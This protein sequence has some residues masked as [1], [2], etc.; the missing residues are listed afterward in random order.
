MKP[1]HRTRTEFDNQRYM[2]IARGL[3]TANKLKQYLFVVLVS[4]AFWLWLAKDFALSILFGKLESGSLAITCITGLG[5]LF[6][7]GRLTA[8]E[9]N[10][11][12]SIR[13]T[14][15][16]GW[17]LTFYCYCVFSGILSGDTM[18]T[19]F[20]LVTLLISIIMAYA[21]A[22]K[23]VQAVMINM[24]L[25]GAIGLLF[26]FAGFFKFHS[27]LKALSSISIG[28]R[29]HGMAHLNIQD[30]YMFIFLFALAI[31]ILEKI[32][33]SSILFLFTAASVSAPMII[34]LN[35]RMIPMTMLITMLYVLVVFRSTLFNSNNRVKII[36]LLIGIFFTIV[37]AVI[38]MSGSET[39]M[40]EAY[41]AGYK[42]SFSDDPRA[43]SF[44]VALG[45]FMDAPALGIGFGKF[46]FP[47]IPVDALD[48]TAGTWPHNLF[49]E[50][51]SELGI[52]GLLLFAVFLLPLIRKTIAIPTKNQTF[53]VLLPCIFFIYTLATLQL[54]HNLSYPLLWV[55]IFWC[56]S[57]FNRLPKTGRNRLRLKFDTLRPPPSHAPL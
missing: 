19:Y 10:R 6:A 28:L 44:Q 11:T 37:V 57:I 36:T 51:L 54:T 52:T 29:A 31:F 4:S 21:L 34:A 48:R 39:R 49:L 3:A 43:I 22:E 47:G 27:E 1:F 46:R 16:L 53:R 56:D 17:A 12:A 23:T 5:L 50:L 24:K 33:L 25:F 20:K 32:S 18:F 40:A 41:N 30:F 38:H 8:T 13:L 26:G 2:H 7:A 9:P 35:S 15:S 55:T 45:N 14:R 42:N